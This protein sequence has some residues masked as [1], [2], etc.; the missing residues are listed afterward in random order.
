MQCVFVT[1][2]HVKSLHNRLSPARSRVQREHSVFVEAQHK[3]KKGDCLA[4]Q[5]DTHHQNSVFAANVD[6]E[7]CVYKLE[8]TLA[9]VREYFYHHF[10]VLNDLILFI[11]NFWLPVKNNLLLL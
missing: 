8:S 2:L 9:S 10:A 1:S 11:S 6:G 3:L 7:T 4:I 5:A